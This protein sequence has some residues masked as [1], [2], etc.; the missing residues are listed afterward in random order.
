MGERKFTGAIAA[1]ASAFLATAAY[2]ES[3]D[4]TINAPVGA[5]VLNSPTAV[6]NATAFTSADGTFSSSATAAAGPGYLQGASHATLDLPNGA[7]GTASGF[8]QESSD[9]NLDN[10]VISGPAGSVVRY[11]I[12]VNLSGS[13][14]AN[15][16]GVG[17]F[18]ASA[19]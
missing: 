12:N 17:P 9:F 8:A 14:G 2:A 4:Y 16:S 11:T 1:V 7:L 15:T 5:Q 6:G 13:I 3:F 18:F 10:I 19:S